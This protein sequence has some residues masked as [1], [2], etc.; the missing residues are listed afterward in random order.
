MGTRDAFRGKAEE[1][2]ARRDHKETERLAK[3]T[4]DRIAEDEKTA[5]LRVLR[6]AKEA[7][8]TQAAG[9]AAPRRKAAKPRD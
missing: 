2:L 8:D 7:A 3:R 4:K 9:A 5:R 6:L 1:L